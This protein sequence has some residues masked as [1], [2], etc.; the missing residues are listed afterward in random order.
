MVA[1]PGHLDGA[2]TVAG[3]AWLA[4]PAWLL[5]ATGSVNPAPQPA[6]QPIRVVL[7]D[8]T[9]PSGGLR[10][11]SGLPASMCSSLARTTASSMARSMVCRSSRRHLQTRPVRQTAGRRRSLTTAAA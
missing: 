3:D 6:T 4:L 11:G 9:G 1:L 5:A 10:R 7:D 8:G 2:R